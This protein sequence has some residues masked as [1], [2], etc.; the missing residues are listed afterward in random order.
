MLELHHQSVSAN[1][2]ILRGNCIEPFLDALQFGKKG[3]RKRTPTR[4]HNSLA[5]F[6]RCGRQTMRSYCSI[7]REARLLPTMSGH[8]LGIPREYGMPLFEQYQVTDMIAGF[9]TWYRISESIS[10]V[11]LVIC[12]FLL[13]SWVFLPVEKTRR[14]YLSICLVIG[15]ILEAVSLSHSLQSQ[16]WC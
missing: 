10:A 16:A 4:L 2:T 13:L 14:H 12:I 3:G 8:G 11:G 6:S 5:K 9:Q 1:L 7:A 15:I